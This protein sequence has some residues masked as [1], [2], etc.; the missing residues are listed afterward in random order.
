M[1]KF[2]SA[3]GQWYFIQDAVTRDYLTSDDSGVFLWGSVPDSVRAPMWQCFTDG[4]GE[5]VGEGSRTAKTRFLN[6]DGHVLACD[7]EDII[8]HESERGDEDDRDGGDEARCN[9]N[10]NWIIIGLRDTD[11]YRFQQDT[12]APAGAEPEPPLYLSRTR[13]GRVEALPLFSRKATRE[14]LIRS[15]EKADRLAWVLEFGN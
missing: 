2:Q 7:G 13:R 10:G 1:A 3:Q 12:E 11:T 8:C 4:K 9:W 6:E 14:W 15:V 5:R